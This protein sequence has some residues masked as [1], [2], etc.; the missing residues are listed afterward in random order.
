MPKCLICGKE[1]QNPNSRSHINSKYHQD[2]M[3]RNNIK[4][5]KSQISV[6]KGSKIV[7]LSDLN[8]LK[9]KVNDLEKRINFIE[10]QLN[11]VLSNQNHLMSN[12]HTQNKDFKTIDE[13]K[14]IK[15]IK[16]KSN[17]QYI[18]GN[19]ILAE[20]K[21]EFSSL[22]SISD[23]QFEEI[24]LRLYRKQIIDLQ[25]GGNPSEYHIISPTGTK[26]YYLILK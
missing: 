6:K 5:L 3:N 22:Y 24:I 13:K 19:L 26:F 23:K 10:N 7:D 25:P 16:R 20:L 11:R 14:I 21:Q 17:S 1:L 18:K 2:R 9:V 15:V 8:N 12:Y 4:S